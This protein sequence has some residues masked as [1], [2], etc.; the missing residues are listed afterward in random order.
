M[1]LKSP[2]YYLT[3]WYTFRT[4]LGVLLGTVIALLVF[5]SYAVELFPIH[6]EDRLF[7]SNDKP[8][9]NVVIV[10]IDDQSIGDQKAGHF[11]FSR[12]RFATVLDNLHAAGAAVTVF[13]VGFSESTAGNGDDKFATA[14]GK[15]GPAVLAYGQGGLSNGT[16][17]YVF[18]DSGDNNRPL[19]KFICGD[20]RAAPGCK[21]V[22]ELGAVAV[23]LDT[24]Q[25]VR[26][27]P[28]FLEAPCVTKDTAGRCTAGTLNPLAFLAYRAWAAQ[29][30][31]GSDLQYT[32]GGATFGP[33]WPKPLPVDD[34]GTA[35]IGWSGGPTYMK[36]HGQYVSFW[37]AYTNNFDRSKVDG[38]MVLIGV[39]G[40]TA[41]HDEQLVAPG[42]PNGGNVMNGVEIHANV[43]QML[44]SNGV[45]FVAPEPPAAVLLSILA[46]CL[47]LGLFLPRL[48]AFYGLV[49]T[50]GAAVIYS[51]AWVPL[52]TILRMVPDFF[53]VWLAIG[54]TYAALM[55]YRF[56]FEEREKRKVTNLFGQYL[57][58]ELVETMARARSVEDIEIGGER[59]ELSLLFVDIRGFTHMSES[60]EPQDVLRVIDV[61]LEGLSS[62]VFRW[63][64]T[65]D[66]YVGDEIMAFWNAPHDQAGHALLAVRCAWEMVARMPELNATL[67]AQG[68][69]EIKYGIGINTGP[70][71]IGIMGSQRRRTYTAIGDTVNTAA[72]FCGH[73]GPTQ[74]LIG[75][76]TYEQ[77]SDYVAVDMVPGV[78]LKGKSAEK[79]T[80]YRVTA[81][82]EAPGKP[83]ATVPGLDTYSEVGV[84][85]QQTMIGA[86]ATVSV[87]TGQP[88]A[89][90][91]LDTA[92][93]QPPTE[94]AAP[95]G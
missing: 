28:M 54:F 10:G 44:D 23:I 93:F 78:Q 79:F 85:N 16:H 77:C 14:I 49:A 89:A 31:T 19:D 11:P 25:V 41:I 84:Y 68:L 38:K 37:D 3:H 67:A 26:R 59:K 52:S 42:G 51:A 33:T 76:T 72:R 90:N 80:I 7:P 83:W 29:G 32:A 69:P 81:I 22:A 65:L 39:Y 91:L 1:P 2:L 8:D 36:A 87:E 56:L 74:I 60:M 47:L 73:A 45:K 5:G 35:T 86:G 12:D 95:V 55:A 88:A 18:T 48:S 64:G 17:D 43:I 53:H 6:P 40:A 62:I 94:P 30:A 27:M 92:E 58:P 57:K 9:S 70:A 71:S 66:K 20:P 75:Q 15:D 46:I 34:F 50:V 82:R 63:D 4:L 13:D 21:P 24:D 61:Y